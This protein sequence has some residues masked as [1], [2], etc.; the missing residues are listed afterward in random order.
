MIDPGQ[1]TEERILS[2]LHDGCS[3]MPINAAVFGFALLSRQSGRKTALVTANMDVFADVVLRKLCSGSLTLYGA[4]G[5]ALTRR[6]RTL[7]HP[8]HRCIASGRLFNVDLRNN[9]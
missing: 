6:H 5:Y 7:F 3:N 4:S 1:M 2:A 8:S 9:E